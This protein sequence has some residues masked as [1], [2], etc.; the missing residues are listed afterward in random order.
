MSRLTRRGEGIEDEPMRQRNKA[1]GIGLAAAS[2][3]AAAAAR[4]ATS[5]Q[6]QRIQLTPCFWGEGA[7]FADFN[8]DGAMDVIYGPWI[9]WGPDFKGRLAYA[10]ADR[11]FTAKFPDGKTRTLPGYEGALGFKNAYADCFFCFVDDFNRDGRPDALIVGLPGEQSYWYENPGCN[12]GLWRRHPALDV[13]DN[14][15]PTYVDLTGDGRKELV[16]CS[17]GYIGY[18]E[19]SWAAPDK[20]WTFRPI[21]PKG[22]YQKYTHGLGVGDVNG[23][24]RMDVIEKDGWWEQP[25]AGAQAAPWR[26]HPYPFAPEGA[27]QM[28]AYDI[29]GDGDNDVL[30]C[31][32]PH[33]YGLAWYEQVVESGK[34]TF[35]RHQF[36]GKT[37][38]ENR[39]GVHFS[40]PHA[41]ALADMDGDGLLDL[42]TGKRFWAHGP[43]GDAEPNA[44]AV[45]YWFRLTRGPRG[46]EY[47]PHLIDDDSGVGTQVVAGDVNGDGRPD[48]V[49]GNKKGA[50]VFLQRAGGK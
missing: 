28:Y 6:F 15:S 48:I 13:P 9:F 50:W 37:A 34:M 24:G 10:P 35:R 18:A 14:E 17:R 49:V 16:C 19:P 21:T 20:P 46:A 29:D 25:A 36:M 7:N 42:V 4:S 27:A 33:H 32:N 45:L 31:L 40:Q 22:K 2:F 38:A 1:F 41:L 30:T 5:P 23:D 8:Q 43:E 47:V 3:L 44:A 39:Y 11:T 26:F 12:K